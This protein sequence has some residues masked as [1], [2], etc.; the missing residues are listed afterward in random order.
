MPKDSVF[1]NIFKVGGFRS[2]M[3]V[4][5][6]GIVYLF[7]YHRNMRIIFMS[8]IAAFLLG[9]YFD[10]RGIELIALCVTITLVFM[11]EIFNTAIELMM[12]MLTDEYNTRIKLIKDIAAAVVVLA[13][14][15]AI[16]VGYVL[17]IRRFF[18]IQLF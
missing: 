6:K 13:C 14:L 5:V 17:F 18:F 2:S 10:L 7:L 16:A 3:K 9:L 12:D 1:R 8:G 15:N 11:A 4:A